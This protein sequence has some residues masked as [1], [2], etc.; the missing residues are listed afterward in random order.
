MNLD[1]FGPSTPDQLVGIAVRCQIAQKL[2]TST[3][4]HQPPTEP[5]D[6]ARDVSDLLLL[7]DLVRLEGQLTAADIGTACAALF[8]AR[9][10]EAAALGRSPR[11]WP[12]VVHAHPH[13]QG[14]YDRVAR[15]SR[16]SHSLSDAVAE[17]NSWII[18]LDA[19]T[20]SG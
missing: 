6:R 17:L 5:N 3:D 4:P 10:D 12:P 19:A 14:D 8:Q 18:E 13:W 11:V 16:I 1:H 7:R 2:H 9:A 20:P 15:E